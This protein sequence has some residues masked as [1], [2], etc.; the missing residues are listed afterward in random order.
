MTV[1]KH[2][3]ISPS[4]QCAALLACISFMAAAS[5]V[6]AQQPTLLGGAGPA[7][8]NP[9]R[10]ESVCEPSQLDSAFIPVDSWV[11]P[12]VWRLYALGFLDTVSLGMRPYTGARLQHMWEQ[13]QAHI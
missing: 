10:P 6:V 5:P 11:Y 7:N 4:I 2:L 1:R 9:G 13:A 8:S 3:A 12:A